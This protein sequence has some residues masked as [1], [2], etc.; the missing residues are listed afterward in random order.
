[1]EATT[2]SEG[3]TEGESLPRRIRHPLLTALL[4]WLL[5]A[6]IVAAVSGP[7]L[8]PSIRRPSIPDFPDWAGWAFGGLS[9]AGAVCVLALFRWRR[10]GFYGYLLVA[11]GV[12]AVNVAAGVGPGPAALGFVGSV[13]LFLTL[14]VGGPKRAWPQLA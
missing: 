6:N 9:A 10:W 14:Q 5:V 13:I 12:F 3:I 1:V 11:G 8:L 7:F 4:V 2:D